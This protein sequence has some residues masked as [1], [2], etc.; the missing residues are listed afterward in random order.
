MAKKE[1][2]YYSPDAIIGRA[3][4]QADVRAKEFEEVKRKLSPEEQAGATEQVTEQPTPPSRPPAP[5]TG[6][7]K[8]ANPNAASGGTI[9]FEPSPDGSTWYYKDAKVDMQGRPI[10]TRSFLGFKITPQGF[11]P[12]GNPYFGAGGSAWLQKWAYKLSEDIADKEVADN[13]WKKFS[14]TSTKFSENFFNPVS[15]SD[16]YSTDPEKRAAAKEAVKARTKENIGLFVQGV[17]ELF[18]A[19]TKS[20]EVAEKSRFGYVT[21]LTYAARAVNAT[22]GMTLEAFTAISELPERSAG[23]VRAMREYADANGSVLPNLAFDSEFEIDPKNVPVYVK[24]EKTFEF[25]EELG[26]FVSRLVLPGLQVYDELRFFTSPGSAKEKWQAVQNGWTEGRMLYTEVVKES[27]RQEYIQRVKAGD[28]PML[29]TMEL[30]DPWIEAAG[31]IIFDP[32]N[33]VGALGKAKKAAAFIDESTRVVTKNGLLNKAEFVDEVAGLGKISNDLE[34]TQKLDNIVNHVLQESTEQSRRIG[35][36]QGYGAA[37][38][39]PEANKIHHRKIFGNYFATITQAIRNTGGSA[40]D[41]GDYLNAIR[42]LSSQDRQL[43]KEGLAT[44]SNMPLKVMAFNDSAFEVGYYLNKIM[45]DG[46]LIKDMQ[47][48]GGNFTELNKYLDGKIDK[49]MDFAFPSVRQMSNAADKAAELAKAGE[50]IDDA[51]KRL[52]D[53]YEVLKKEHP[54]YVRWSKFHDLVDATLKPVNA[55]LSNNYFSLSYGYAFRNLTQNLVTLFVDDGVTFAKGFMKFD[56]QN[57]FVTPKLD[58]FILKQNAG[59]MPDVFRMENT[60][61]GK[62]TEGSLGSRFFNWLN[63]KGWSPAKMSQA[64]EV[65]S[66]KMIYTKKFRQTMDSIAVPGGMFPEVAKWVDA[67]YTPEQ[68]NDFAKLFR[69]NDYDINATTQAFARKY[70]DGAVDKW[71]MM[72][73]VTPEV[74]RG[75]K[76]YGDYWDQVLRAVNDP[77]NTYT[78]VLNKIDDLKVQ[79]HKEA[80][81]AALT[82]A[83]LNDKDELAKVVMEDGSAAG[84][85]TNQAADNEL[86]NLNIHAESAMAEYRDALTKMYRQVPEARSQ[87]V[88]DAISETAHFE[89]RKTV[90]TQTNELREGVIA[91]RDKVYKSDNLAA[92]WDTNLMGDLPT[93]IITRDTFTKAMWDGYYLK[94]MTMWNDFFDDTLLRYMEFAKSS[95][96]MAQL[97]D[98]ANLSNL[99]LQQARNY[100]YNDKGIFTQ[101]PKIIEAPVGTAQN[102]TTVRTLGVTYGVGTNDKHLL[103]TINKYSGQKF[104]SLNNVPPDVAEKVFAERMGQLNKHFVVGKVDDAARKSDVEEITKTDFFKDLKSKAAEERAK[105]AAN[106]LPQET[107]SSEDIL[108]ELDEANLRKGEVPESGEFK[109]D[110]DAA[111]RQ[112]DFEDVT[113]TDFYKKLKADA[114]AAREARKTYAAN[115]ITEGLPVPPARDPYVSPGAHS[116]AEN[117]DGM[118]GALNYLRNGIRERAGMRVKVGTAKSTLNELMPD[119]TERMAIANAKSKYVAEKYRDFALLPYGEKTNFD[120]AMS[121]VYP[122]QFWYSRTYSNWM[123][124]AFGSNPEIISRYANLKEAMASEHKDLPDWWKSQLNVSKLFGIETE[125]PMYINLESALFPLYGLTGTDFNDPQKRVNWWTATLDDMG[126]FGPSIFAPIQLATAAVLFAQGEKD[127]ASKWGGRL[128]PQTATVKAV[129]SFFGTPIELDPAVQ[130]FSGDGLLD[131]QA[132]DS[133][134]ESRIA[135]ALA[136][137][138]AQGVPEEQLI[139]AARTHKGQLWDQAYRNAV[140]ERAPGQLLSFLFGTGYKIRTQADIQ[141]DR[142]YADYYRMKNLRDGGYMTSDQYRQAFD[143]MREVYPFM[144][145]LLLSRR[146]GDGR[147]AAY[148]YNV[149]SRIPPGMSSEF[150]KIIGVDQET[151][152][153]FYDSG[154][155]LDVMSETEQARFMAAM[156][157]L[158][159]MM[160]IPNNTTRQEWTQVRIAYNDMNAELTKIYGEDINDK[161]SHYYGI[162]DMN[163][164]RAYLERHPEVEAAQDA[165][166]AMIVGSPQLMKYYGGIETLEKYYTGNMYDTLEE[167]FGKEIFDVEDAYYDILDTDERKKYRNEHPELKDYWDRKSELKEE[168]QRA[169]VTFGSRLPD[170]PK[171][172]TTGK[173]PENPTEERLQEFINQPPAPTFE[174]W[175]QELGTPM[176]DLIQDY[177]FNDEELPY[178][179]SNSLDYMAE[180]YGYESGDDMLRAILMSMQP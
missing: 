79:V 37:A 78:D 81:K 163:D 130:M 20:V 11:D 103:S 42:K 14:E 172:Q 113:S 25:N 77:N 122:Y 148:A 95:P 9:P 131:F 105:R 94:R 89:R 36:F 174:Q 86:I 31:E 104:D 170:A 123:K 66:G 175:Q 3:Q 26:N 121:M 151:A 12:L 129:S 125:N 173:T 116:F 27:V 91:L 138:K 59:R 158:G 133:Y 41:V 83:Q 44:V 137:M 32:L 93:G 150:Y 101:P 64:F 169:L 168:N 149:M 6:T 178:T 10:Q 56:P 126:K 179:V 107:R 108:R 118:L 84:K 50:D 159:A 102:A 76:D 23:A 115:N 176:T 87:E 90:I 82:P 147:D 69:A 45:G 18:S 38:L 33:F 34:G 117:R 7:R 171:L 67:G 152:Q 43:I 72:D 57:G 156:V 58:D 155:K 54:G 109:V 51:T 16:Y 157:D 62:T 143:K 17:Q 132:S 4:A 24:P 161:I 15:A 106:R 96:D 162:D 80:N 40:D 5:P 85:F 22:V 135:R 63:S 29:L 28:D 142:F 154:G 46:D 39:T 99:K 112:Q 141:T 1:K 47:K 71:R 140:M 48:L 177:W 30:E 52:S 153:K 110:I 128:I 144:D 146:S 21:P 19:S 160:K 73:W 8:T 70:G 35:N 88:F 13:A 60:F 114:A 49:A 55:F 124:R 61:I 119:I 97:F 92:L 98:K 75:L 164:A 136:A 167:E 2:G 139:E 145:V 111:K 65:Y 53:A 74:E 100:I 134:E 180:Q 120:L 68:A 166:T 127:V 165:K